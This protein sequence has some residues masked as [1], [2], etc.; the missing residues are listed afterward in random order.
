MIR[1]E[2]NLQSGTEP[3]RMGRLR[4]AAFVAG[5]Y[6]LAG[7]AWIVGSD[8]LLGLVIP[9]GQAMLAQTLKGL[10]FVAVTGAAL[11][12][13]LSRLLDDAQDAARSQDALA[14]EVRSRA[15]QQ[16]RLA[17]RLMHAEEETR[18]AVAKDLHDGPLQALTLTFMQLDAAAR[19]AAEGAAVE[20]ERVS[21]AMEAIRDASDDIRAVVR[22]LHPPLL[23]EL[24]LAAAV[25][26]QC[27]EAAQ[28]TG[29]EV[30]YAG[31]QTLAPLD[32]ERSIAVFRILQEALANALKHTQ[33]G[34]IRVDLHEQGD[35][36]QLRVTDSGPGFH[37]E[38]AAGAGLGLVSMRERAESVGAAFSVES[39]P[40]GGTSVD[41]RIPLGAVRAAPSA[42]PATAANA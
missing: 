42:V 10:G 12:L 35:H 9:D 26:R 23:A 11:Y 41:V 13:M 15:R 18:R 16:R 7:S 40:R 31:Q 17:H 28:R 1:T 14:A 24:G 38:D 2:T 30:V 33:D 34:H 8:W 32:A 22:A 27:R 39:R 6:A 20:P 3:A 19:S 4:P 21:A 5:V 37:P 25:E 36:L 29:R